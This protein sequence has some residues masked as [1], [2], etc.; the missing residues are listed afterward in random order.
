[1]PTVDPPNI[2]HL[3]SSGATYVQL[4][5]AANAITNARKMTVGLYLLQR[6]FLAPT[7]STTALR[8]LQMQEH[9]FSPSTSHETEA[10]WDAVRKGWVMPTRIR[11]RRSEKFQALGWTLT[12]Q[13]AAAVEAA[14]EGDRVRPGTFTS[15]WEDAEIDWRDGARIAHFGRYQSDDDRNDHGGNDEDRS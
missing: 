13:G 5:E 7:V 11:R 6:T 8:E 14:F 1:M 12:S 15:W 10:L 2:P 3:L 4:I 9:V